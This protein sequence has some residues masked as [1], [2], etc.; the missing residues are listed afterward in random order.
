MSRTIRTT[1]IDQ[2]VINKPAHQ[3]A[4]LPWRLAGPG[5]EIMLATSRETKRWVTL[6]GW[7]MPGRSAAQS[8]S[9]EAFE[10]AGVKGSVTAQA[11]G[12]FSYAKRLDDGRVIDLRVDVYAL[13][14]RQQLADWP[15]RGER[16]IRWFHPNEAARLVAEPELAS[17]IKS[18]A[19]GGFMRC[20]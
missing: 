18:F 10:E 20:A 17:L 15:E 3:V 1:A 7:P 19:A 11:I 6:K 12:E 8:A 14:V 13:R 5:I 2:T 4:A 9:R 16:V